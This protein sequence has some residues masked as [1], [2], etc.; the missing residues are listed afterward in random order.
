MPE[1]N[2]NIIDIKTIKSRGFSELL[3]RGKKHKAKHDDEKRKGTTNAMMVVALPMFGRLKTD[4]I[5]PNKKKEKTKYM[6]V[7]ATTLPITV[8]E[9]LH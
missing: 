9:P 5:N 6:V 3:Y 1:K 7:Y 2:N 4:G 8:V